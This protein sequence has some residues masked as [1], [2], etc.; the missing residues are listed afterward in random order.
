MTVPN[1]NVR[2]T[3]RDLSDYI[4]TSTRQD[5]LAFD[6]FAPRVD[7][8]RFPLR[9]D[10]LTIMMCT[11]GQATVIVDLTEYHLREN[12]LLVLQP[13]NFIQMTYCSE[14][15]SSHT[16]VCSK[17]VVGQILPKLSAMLP[18]IM[19]HRTMPLQQLT[20][21]EAMGIES[22][23]TFLKLKLEEEKTPFQEQKVLC[24]LQAALYEIMDIR[25]AHTEVRQAQHSRKEEI[26]ARF[27]LEV[28]RHFQSERQVSFYAKILCVT[29]KHLSSVVKEISGRTAGEW[30]DHYVVMEAKMLLGSTDMTVQEISM[31]LNFANQSF[32]GKYFKHHTGISPTE[33]RQNNVR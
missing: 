9:I 20:H 27:I 25:M 19:Q 31:Q 17:E 10:G 8:P 5:V 22:F 12:S 26:M 21:K 30:I 4:K 3:L 13:E 18:L 29:P 1:P 14:D 16:V 6:T 33:F 11:A 7:M 24:M 23:Y 28:C 2:I 15:F 32:F